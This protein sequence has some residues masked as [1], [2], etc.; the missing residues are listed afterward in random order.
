MLIR[1][2][3]DDNKTYKVVAFA[4][5]CTLTHN[6]MRK[7]N[8]IVALVASVVLLGS[9]LRDGDPQPRLIG[10]TTFINAFIEATDVYCYIDRGTISSLNPLPYRSYGPFEPLYAYPGDRR[11]E[12]YSTYQENRLVDTTVT[13]QD[14]VFYSSIVYGTHDDPRHFITEDRIPEGVDDPTAIAA[15]RFYN[16]ANSDRRMTL[17]IEGLELPD[18]FTSRPTE[19]PE[20]GKSSEAF[21]PVATGTYTVSVVDEDG[22]TVAK[23]DGTL[24]LSAGKYV[25]IFL[26]GDERN[27][28]T[29]YVGRVLH[30]VN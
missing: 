14:S 21:I 25:S 1:I 22:N 24:D 9:C 23:R 5:P 27:P 20:T 12:I 19:T 8:F 28:E 13:V 10:G 17:R 2:R 26:T 15:I 18:R 4:S 7:L 6:M 29:F 3:H 30:W 11:F 16:L